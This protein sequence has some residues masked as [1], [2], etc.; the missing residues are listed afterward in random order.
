MRPYNY[1]KLT[2]LAVGLFIFAGCSNSTTS[3]ERRLADLENRVAQL[4]AKT[5]A[6]SSN[7]PVSN[8]G[9]RQVISPNNNTTNS[10]ASSNTSGTPK[11]QFTKETHDFGTISE[12]EV[13]SHTFEFTNAGDAPLVINSASASCGCTVPSWPREPIAPGKSGRI[14]VQF[15]SNNKSGIQ[16]KSVTLKANTNPA[17]KR[18]RIRSEIVSGN[19]GAAGPVRNN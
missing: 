1:L 16:N 10:N 18:L 5:N 15:D 12:G 11:F 13:V 3:L 7:N 8:S 6:M 4:E 19:S 2:M 9:N 17:T 14:K